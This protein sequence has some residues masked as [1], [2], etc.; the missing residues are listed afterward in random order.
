MTKWA[1][2][3]TLATVLLLILR[4]CFTGRYFNSVYNKCGA[5]KLFNLAEVFA[6]F[7]KHAIYLIVNM[8][9]VLIFFF[10]FFILP[11]TKRQVV[12]FPNAVQNV[13]CRFCVISSLLFLFEKVAVMG[14]FLV[15][16]WQ[17]KSSHPAVWFVWVRLFN[18]KVETS[19]W[20]YPN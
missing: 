12:C 6:L 16:H 3:L 15:S 2:L 7:T 14:L 17:L 13:K 20:L 19:V 1:E 11:N 18:T 4:T 8:S 9:Y 10:F 5:L